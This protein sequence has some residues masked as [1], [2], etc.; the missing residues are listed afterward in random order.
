MLA[1]IRG[2]VKDEE[3]VYLFLDNASYHKNSEVKE[4]MKKLNIEP[5]LNVAYHF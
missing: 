4:E 5:I 1:D 2:A 3:V